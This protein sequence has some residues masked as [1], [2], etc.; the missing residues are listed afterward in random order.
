MISLGD[1]AVLLGLLVVPAVVV[2]V[3]SL[4]LGWLERHLDLPDRPAGVEGLPVGADLPA[5]RSPVA[6][7]LWALPFAV[8]SAALVLAPVVVAVW[9]VVADEPA[10]GLLV[11]VAFGIGALMV[12]RL[13]EDRTSAPESTGPTPWSRTP[14]VLLS[15]AVGF[16][17]AIV[18]FLGMQLADFL[19]FDETGTATIAIA[20]V[21][22]IVMGGLAVLA[23]RRQT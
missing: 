5:E 15:A 19:G 23:W 22:A 1:V 12:R 9:S 13:V 6:A 10:A 20:L 21:L 18:G 17:I 14:G 8:L 2:V 7:M 4:V 16:T 3:S 11:T